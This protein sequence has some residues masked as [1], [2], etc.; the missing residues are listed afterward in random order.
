MGRRSRAVAATS[1]STSTASERRRCFP[2]QAR[3]TRFGQDAPRRRAAT[4]GDS[5]RWRLRPPRLA[6]RL[7]AATE[8]LRAP[9][10]RRRIEDEPLATDA[11]ARRRAAVTS[12]TPDAPTDD[13]VRRRG[14]PGRI[15]RR[16]RRRQG[17]S[18][19]TKNKRRKKRRLAGNANATAT[20]PRAAAAAGST[21]HAAVAARAWVVPRAVM[22][23][24]FG[25]TKG[26]DLAR[27]GVSTTKKRR[28]FRRE[29]AGLER[30]P[31]REL[32]RRE[33]LGAAERALE[34]RRGASTRRAAWLQR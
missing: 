14:S 30:A 12:M 34:P 1:P 11:L 31:R 24:A 27:D 32:G 19:R 2:L 20:G 15:D 28:R 7:T 5:P 18:F 21:S 6:R 8:A 26:F 10:T 3:T 23:D 17:V 13:L 22:P 16:R 4:P 9:A 25:R 29:G 33:R